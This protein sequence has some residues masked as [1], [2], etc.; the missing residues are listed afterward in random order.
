MDVSEI[1]ERDSHIALQANGIRHDCAVSFQ[2][3]LESVVEIM[4]V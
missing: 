4:G 3:E 1:A 2:E